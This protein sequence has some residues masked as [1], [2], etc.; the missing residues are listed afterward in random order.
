[1][2]EPYNVSQLAM[3]YDLRKSGKGR[4]I[5]HVQPTKNIANE[6]LL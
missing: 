3:L 6:W 2:A 5:L 4:H 1:M